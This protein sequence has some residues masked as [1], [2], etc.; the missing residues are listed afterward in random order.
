MD[1]V[2]GNASAGAYQCRIAGKRTIKHLPVK[3]GDIALTDAREGNLILADKSQDLCFENITSLACRSRLLI[4]RR[5]CT[6]F[7]VINCSFKNTRT[8]LL[9]APSGGINSTSD[10]VWFEGC[11]FEGT[12]DDAVNLR[13][14]Q[15]VVRN[16]RIAS[17]YRHTIWVHEARHWIAGN[18]LEWGGTSGISL[19]GTGLSGRADSMVQAVVVEGNTVRQCNNEGLK[20]ESIKPSKVSSTLAGVPGVPKDRHSH[21]RI[22][23][24]T[25]I[26]TGCQP[27]ISLCDATSV[28]LVDNR[29]LDGSQPVPADAKDDAPAGISRKNVTDYHE[30]GTIIE[31]KRIR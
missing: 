31:D 16:C 8:G 24:N 21:I 15:N 25:F 22:I 23:G 30:E 27:V 3:V 12:R 9:A 1:V 2:P 11:T 10:Q 5:D 19:G 17:A 14:Q 4:P 20:L 18:V 28:F 13:A 26:G 6:G 29:L 7:R